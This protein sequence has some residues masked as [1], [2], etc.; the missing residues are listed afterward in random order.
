MG[1]TVRIQGAGGEW[2]I[3]DSI[4]AISED[5]LPTVM[6]NALYECGPL[7]RARF[8]LF[9]QNQFSIG[10]DFRRVQL[11][12]LSNLA[13]GTGLGASIVSVSGVNLTWVNAVDHELRT[14]FAERANRRGWLHSRFTYDLALFFVGI[15]ICLDTVYVID[16][17]LTT[18]VSF[19]PAVFVALYVYLVLVGLLAF[20][21]LF[22]YAKWVFPKIEGPRQRSGGAALHKAILASL[23]LA[24][25][26]RVVTTILWVA[27]IHLH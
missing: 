13:L 20:R 26:M 2:R 12:D 8:N 7:Y 14:F 6:T 21:V 17:R 3:T 22:N 25:L 4:A 9:P 24:L 23:G 18:L 1:L 11:G 27:G 5:S 19:P 16:R 10:I 15:P